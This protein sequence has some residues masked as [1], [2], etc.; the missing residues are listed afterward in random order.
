MFGLEFLKNYGARIQLG[1]QLD[2]Y[3]KQ[4]ENTSEFN[5]NLFII[6]V[7]SRF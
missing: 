2:R 6:Q 1:L 4:T 3:K 7:Q 5:K